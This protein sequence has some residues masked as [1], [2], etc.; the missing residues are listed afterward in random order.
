MQRN[1]VM[2]AYCTIML[3]LLYPV[4]IFICALNKNYGHK[5]IDEYLK[6]LKKIKNV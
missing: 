6:L 1:Y 2:Q 3:Y 5:T 4:S